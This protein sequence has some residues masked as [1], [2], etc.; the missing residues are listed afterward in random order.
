MEFF[1]DLHP[2]V[3]HF[4]IA[5]LIIYAAFEAVGAIF[6][7]DFFSKAAHLFLLLGV[8][9]LVAALLTGE[10]AE[11]MAEELED[12]GA[13][14]PFRAINEHKDWANITIWYFTG[15]LIVR[16]VVVIKKKFIGAFQYIFVVLAFVG[17]FFIYETAEHG[18]ILVYKYGVGT[19]LLKETIED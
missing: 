6:K 16:S 4:P 7:K 9:G 12:L 19:D 5:F 3:V 15:L 18:G 2:K 10:R 8:I 13:L 14:I 17:V 11:A 1:A